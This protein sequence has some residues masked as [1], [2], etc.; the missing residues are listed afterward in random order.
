MVKAG[1]RL[2]FQTQ[3]I[4]R[5]IY[6]TVKD[7]LLAALRRRSRAPNMP[8][9]QQYSS[10]SP[11]EMC[12]DTHG[13]FKKNATSKEKKQEK[14]IHTHTQSY[15]CFPLL[16]SL[17]LR[18]WQNKCWYIDAVNIFNRFLE[19]LWGHQSSPIDQ[20][21]LW[22]WLSSLCSRGTVSDTELSCLRRNAKVS[23]PPHLLCDC[24]W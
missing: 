5:C 3:H 17:C 6:L 22:R 7:W 10:V 14:P 20:N 15:S 16:F 21:N 24:D 23:S 1:H 4:W 18:P 12:C 13:L 2:C 9:T 8:M 19:T 11:Q